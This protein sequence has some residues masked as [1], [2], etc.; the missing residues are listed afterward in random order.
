[1]AFFQINEKLLNYGLHLHLLQSDTVFLHGN[2]ASNRWWDP[3]VK[4]LQTNHLSRSKT[5]KLALF[6]WLGCGKSQEGLKD[7]A[8]LSMD[9]LAGDVIQM[10]KGLGL[11]NVN[12]VGHSTGGVIALYALLKEPSL[13]QRA[14]LLDPVSANGL[15]IEPETYEAFAQMQKNRDFC[16]QV[17]LSTVHESTL[18]DPLMQLLIDD[19]FNVHSLIWKGIPDRLKEIA[20][21]SELKNISMPVRILHGSLDPVLPINDS[22]LMA[23]ELR[24]G[25]FREMT[26]QGHSTNVE[27][28]QRFVRELLDFFEGGKEAGLPLEH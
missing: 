17:M 27:N 25:S 6:E 16:A 10:I 26:G 12:L 2:L 18:D 24:Q 11:A 23:K 1:M 22:R 9:S 28:P 3:V 20:I 21:F 8:Q 19:A 4:E 5:G 13:F 14:L 7:A 15:Q